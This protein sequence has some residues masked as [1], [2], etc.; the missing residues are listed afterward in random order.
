MQLCV[1]A[2]VK[3]L[4][5]LQGSPGG[6]GAFDMTP[7]QLVGV[8]VGRVAR[9]EVQA[10]FAAGGLHVFPDVGLLVRG[11][12]VQDQVNR[13]L[14]PLHHPLEQLDEQFRVQRAL[15]DAEPERTARVHRRGSRQAG[16][17]EPALRAAFLDR[18][19]SEWLTGVAPAVRRVASVC[20][21]ALALAAAG[22]L[23]GRKATTHWRSCDR[24][25]TMFPKVQVQR[26]RVYVRDGPVWTSAGVCTGI[27]LALA[28]IEDDL[29]RQMAVDIARNLALVMFRSGAQPQL[30]PALRAQAEASPAFESW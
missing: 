2:N 19:V 24:L 21:G 27:D 6:A 1:D 4:A 14:A 3:L 17:D 5:C 9:Q 25:Q 23:D 28:L 22:L 11:Q 7:H 18:G 16:G 30:S 15:V 8:Q 29:G 10:E 26:D 12:A 13:L 20:T